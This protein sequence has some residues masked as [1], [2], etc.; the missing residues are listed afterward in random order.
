MVQHIHSLRASGVMSSHFESAAL[1]AINAFFRS[2]GSLCTT[3]SEMI[4]VLMPR[5]I[6]KWLP[7]CTKRETSNTM[8]SM[9]DAPSS[10]YVFH[11]GPIA[12]GVANCLQVFNFL[13]DRLH[14]TYDAGTSSVA[15]L[16]RRSIDI[17]FAPTERFLVTGAPHARAYYPR[18]FA[19]FYPDILDPD[20]LVSEED[21]RNRVALLERSVRLMLEA[22]R[23]N[24][25][26][27]TLVPVGERRLIGV[28]YFFPPSDTLLGILA[29]LEQL[30]RA[31][32]R[33]SPHFDMAPIAKR[34]RELL[35]DYKLD[36]KRAITRMISSLETWRY[37]GKEYLLCDV[38]RPRSA[39]TDTRAER[40]RFVTNASIY[41]SLIRATELGVIEQFE[42]EEL[43]GRSLAEYKRELLQLFGTQGFIRNSMRPASV[44]PRHDVALD[45]V[46]VLRG[47]WDFRDPSERVLF[48]ETARMILS[49]SKFRMGDA[50]HLLVS[51]ENP[52]RKLIHRVAAPEYHGRSAWPSFNV[53]FAHR[54]LEYGATAGTDEFREAAQRILEDVHRMTEEHGGYHELFSETGSPYRTWGYRAAVAHSWFPR[55]VSVWKEAFGETLLSE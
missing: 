24:I 27:T 1:S 48:R 54:L 28:N 35:T 4:A 31:G 52:K 36:L 20:T 13:S 42:L 6:A 11:R 7:N 12:T 30:I 50:D 22:A 26:T 5:S 29:G 34:G 10:T 21:A 2:A 55:F 19:W 49:D 32:D 18:D 40:L 9:A 51:I 39:V 47:F 16:Y 8:R 17:A 33:P 38:S 25:V 46:S 37:E 3:P 45:F 15:D 41:A 44:N 14:R 43:L 53:E 23:A